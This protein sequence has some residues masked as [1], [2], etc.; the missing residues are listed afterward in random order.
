MIRSVLR[1]AVVALLVL[2]S[3]ALA[4]PDNSPQIRKE[5]GGREN[6][7]N[8]VIFAFHLQAM[9]LRYDE[10]QEFARYLVKINMK[11]SKDESAEEFLR[12]MFEA[13]ESMTSTKR[14]LSI[15]VLCNNIP[16]RTKRNIYTSMDNLDDVREAVS[17]SAY[18]RFMMKLNE[19]EKN[20]FRTWLE[21]LKQGYSQVTFDHAS[22]YAT[23]GIDVKVS[24]Q[25]QCIKYEQDK[26]VDA[27]E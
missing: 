25:R 23:S 12:Q 6:T 22:L 24:A 2:P 16:A 3:V 9:A 14:D 4:A 1:F 18:K 13:H 8:H 19:A 20:D 21:D 15:A 11:V 10:D 26:L 7:P 5:Y 17:K 27:Q